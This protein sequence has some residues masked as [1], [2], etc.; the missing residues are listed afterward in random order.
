M[1]VTQSLRLHPPNPRSA[2]R[3][4]LLAFVAMTAG[5]GFLYLLG[6][7]HDQRQQLLQIHEAQTLSLM[8]RSSEPDQP[9]HGCEGFALQASAYV[10]FAQHPP[11]K[12]KQ[13]ILVTVSS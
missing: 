1:P 11:A 12:N 7:S 6:V 5:L 4:G 10:Q 3:S 13:H 2:S 9:S 8:E